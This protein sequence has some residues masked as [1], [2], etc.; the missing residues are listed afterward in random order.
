MNLSIVII[1]LNYFNC[2]SILRQNSTHIISEHKQTLIPALACQVANCLS[3]LST[4]CL[5]SLEAHNYH[6]STL[7][8]HEECPNGDATCNICC[9]NCPNGCC[10]SY[11]G[12]C[13]QCCNGLQRA[14]A[15]TQ[16]DFHTHYFSFH[17]DLSFQSIK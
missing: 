7:N 1:N 17:L 2:Q 14:V 8:A 16:N 3:L 5:Q 13:V 11:H 12:I 9:E 15:T 6:E 4:L 10:H